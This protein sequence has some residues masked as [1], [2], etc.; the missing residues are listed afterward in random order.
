MDQKRY[1]D[2]FNPDEQLILD[3]ARFLHRQLFTTN[4]FPN[5]TSTPNPDIISGK[6]ERELFDRYIAALPQYEQTRE[7]NPNKVDFGNFGINVGYKFHLNVS[8]ANIGRVST[9]L[10]KEGFSHK[11]LSGGEIA[12]GKIFTIYVGAKDKS[13]EMATILS[14]ELGPHLSRPLEKND[15]IEI[16]PN[17][18]GRFRAQGDDF[19]Q[20]GFGLKGIPMLREDARRLLYVSDPTDKKRLLD[21]AFK[22]AFIKLKDVYGQYFYGTKN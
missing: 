9:F 16:A 21:E 6:T 8:I 1:Y 20:Y 19:I 10:K 4:L 11:Y 2:T 15:E 18:S 12:D 22:R 7:Y 14:Q 5:S 13:D 3:Y 17:I